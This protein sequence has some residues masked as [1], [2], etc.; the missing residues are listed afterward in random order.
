MGA[1]LMHNFLQLR[2]ALSNMGSWRIVD[3]DF[4]HDEFYIAIVDYF[5]VI[6]GPVTQARVDE[7]L[8]WWNT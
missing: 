5:E 7:L 8:S 1:S 3:I 4:H 2:F 6:P